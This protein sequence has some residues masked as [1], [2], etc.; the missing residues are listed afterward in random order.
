[1]YKL[2]IADDEAVEREAVQ[3]FIKNSGIQF[4]RIDEA[5]NGI[6]AVE[7]AKK[8]EPDIAVLDIRMPGKSGLDAAREIQSSGLSCRFIFLTAFNEFDYAHQAIKVKAEDFIIKPAKGEDLIKALSKVIEGLDRQMELKELESR[9]TLFTTWFENDLMLSVAKGFI[10]ENRIKDY[11]DKMDIS[12]EDAVCAIIRIR[13]PLQ[14]GIAKQSE[15]NLIQRA[16][17]IIKKLDLASVSRHLFGAANMSVY[18]MAMTDE[19]F[20]SEQ[21]TEALFKRIR[22]ALLEKMEVDIQIGIGKTFRD[23]REASNSFFQAKF[24]SR[25]G[26]ALNVSNFSIVERQKESIKYP[27][28]DEKILC[29]CIIKGDEK[30]AEEHVEAIMD[31]ISQFS[32]SVNW[33]REKT[34]ELTTI[35][36]RA[37]VKEFSIRTVFMQN[38][39]KELSGLQTMNEIIIFFKNF[40]TEIIIRINSLKNSP[41]NQL[42]E[43]ACSYID[44]NISKNIQLEEIAEMLGFS[45]YYFSKIFKRYKNINFVDYITLRRIE[46]AKELLSN[47]RLS[48]KEIAADI[49]YNDPNYFANVFKKREGISPTEYRSKHLG[50]STTTKYQMWKHVH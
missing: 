39:V 12:F 35:V 43:K 40:V 19:S 20:A 34:H 22:S 17:G 46:K 5:S 41:S 38:H 7:I 42:I 36:D 14:T 6:E 25:R 37:V 18:M 8:V 13:Q 50:S 26:S 29:D 27:L 48:V 23:P 32:G 4:D 10:P 1:M 28:K 33:A 15:R 2:L 44:L 45:K 49:G 24:A 21:K 47:L 3:F 11:F 16:I 31:W 9:A 30:A